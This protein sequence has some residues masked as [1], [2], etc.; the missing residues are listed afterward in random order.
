[1]TK[2]NGKSDITQKRL[3]RLK[4]LSERISKK[5]VGTENNKSSEKESPKFSS[6]LKVSCIG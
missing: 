6:G 1:M 3:E 2:R 4:S 5:E